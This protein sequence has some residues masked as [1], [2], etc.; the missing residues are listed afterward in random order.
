MTFT[1]AQRLIIRNLVEYV[2]YYN[3]PQNFTLTREI[4]TYLKNKPLFSIGH[5]KKFRPIIY[6]YPSRILEKDLDIFK[7]TC[8]FYML[9]IQ[10]YLMNNYF[11]ENWVIILDLEKRG[12]TNT[13]YKMLKALIS[14][15][16]LI[17][18]GRMH[19]MFI[20]NPSFLFNGIWKL[21]SKFLHPDTNAKI[22]FLKKSSFQELQQ[23]IDRN[24]LL[25]AY[26]G[27]VKEPESPLPFQPLFKATEVPS[28][29]AE[30]KVDNNYIPSEAA[31]QKPKL[32]EIKTRLLNG[33]EI[34]ELKQNKD[35][36]V[37]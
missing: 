16:S 8:C 22:Q 15:T 32:Q 2:Q 6:V 13:P 7:E 33:F 5:D 12:I 28:L 25:E 19:K 37:F 4:D 10:R 30:D 18:S 11:I 34:A 35:W 21:I 1:S 24:Q 3:N 14:S 23:Y 36:D 27:V 20:L 26:G 9:A 29:T 31:L 17:F